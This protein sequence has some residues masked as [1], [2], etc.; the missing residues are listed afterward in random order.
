M[1]KLD[2]SDWFADPKLSSVTAAPNEGDQANSF[3][4]TVTTTQPELTAVDD[5]TKQGANK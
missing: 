4:M 3:R 5:S 1:R 2:E